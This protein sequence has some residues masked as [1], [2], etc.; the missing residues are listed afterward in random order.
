M[1]ATGRPGG[2]V[3]NEAEPP[4]RA[5]RLT[6]DELLLH[7][8]DEPDPAGDVER[9]ERI[10]REIGAGFAALAPLGK[11]V[12]TFGSARVPPG[13][14][15]YGQAREVAAALGRAGFAVITGGGPG[16]MEAANLGA[17]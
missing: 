7:C 5:G 11:A 16:L 3:V 8:V 15:R 6:S 12:S 9:V 10:R 1:D 17:P 14:P 4:R 13:D 2:P